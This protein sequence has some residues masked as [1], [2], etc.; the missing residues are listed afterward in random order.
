[1]CPPSA[2]VTREANDNK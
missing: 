1:M 2:E